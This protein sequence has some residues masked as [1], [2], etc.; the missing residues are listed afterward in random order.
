MS[1]TCL[2]AFGF[3]MS[4][5]VSPSFLPSA[6]K[7][8]ATTADCPEVEKSGR[9][10]TSLKAPNSG[11]PNAA[12]P[13][14]EVDSLSTSAK[15]SFFFRPPSARAIGSHIALNA[16][17]PQTTDRIGIV[18][19]EPDA[20]VGA[21]RNRNRRILRLAC[22]IFD[23]SFLRVG[24]H[25]QKRASRQGRDAEHRGWYPRFGSPQAF[26]AHSVRIS[27]STRTLAT[28]GADQ[29]GESAAARLRDKCRAARPPAIS[30]STQNESAPAR[31]IGSM[32]ASRLPPSMAMRQTSA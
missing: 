14:P 11:L 4:F 23:E 5:S 1:R 9:L 6:A 2:R 13:L 12:H 10:W 15:P 21:R 32:R 3:A 30:T 16:A 24:A 25:E 7:Y 27:K 19:G 26:A 29:R 18:D 8:S 31:L 28:P 17:V 20:A 22:A